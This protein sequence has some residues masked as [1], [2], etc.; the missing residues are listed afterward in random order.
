MSNTEAAL[1][2]VDLRLH[3]LDV[4][5]RVPVGRSLPEGLGER[6]DP[7]R[8]LAAAAE[9]GSTHADAVPGFSHNQAGLDGSHGA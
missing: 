5:P 8:H 6:R 4:Q 3:A 2:I 7:G 9:S 1:H